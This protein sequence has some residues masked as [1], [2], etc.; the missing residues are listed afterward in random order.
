MEKPFNPSD[1]KYRQVADLPEEN[2]AEFIDVPGEN[3]GGF[4]RRDVVE[5]E[6]SV[7]AAA[8]SDEEAFEQIINDAE[9]DNQGH[10][11]KKHLEENQRKAVQEMQGVSESTKHSLANI[12]SQRCLGAIPVSI[13][14]NSLEGTA[15][16]EYFVSMDLAPDVVVKFESVLSAPHDS[17]TQDLDRKQQGALRVMK[18]KLWHREGGEFERQMMFEAS[19]GS[20]KYFHLGSMKSNCILDVLTVSGDE[21]RFT[22]ENGYH[23]MIINKKDN[24]GRS[25][26]EYIGKPIAKPVGKFVE[27]GTSFEDNDISTGE[28][29]SIKLYLLDNDFGIPL[30]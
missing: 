30:S 18:Y 14:P 28:I 9:Y 20:S 7:R 15:L 11:Y 10:S 12:I 2:Q 6:A 5:Y 1:E 17:N 25:A 4:I 8:K 23:L 16:D 21:F 27:I 29:S 22:G 13:D 19:E 3:G 26:S 24:E